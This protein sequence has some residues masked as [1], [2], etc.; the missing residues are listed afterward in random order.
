MTPED[1]VALLTERFGAKIL[2]SKLGVVSPWVALDAGAI[3]EIAQF[4]RNDERLLMDH[5]ELLGG[6]D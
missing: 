6:V 2:E 1:I 4:L 3:L 5:L